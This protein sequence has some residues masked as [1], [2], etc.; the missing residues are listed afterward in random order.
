MLI[1]RRDW[2]GGYAHAESAY[3]AFFT[4]V[5]SC[6]NLSTLNFRCKGTDIMGNAQLIVFIFMGGDMVC[7]LMW[8]QVQFPAVCNTK[9]GRE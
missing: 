5:A 8:E 4:V 2:G 7:L 6:P 9:A 3:L 1:L